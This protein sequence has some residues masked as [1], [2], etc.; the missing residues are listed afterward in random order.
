MYFILLMDDLV[1]LA[2]EY[3]VPERHLGFFRYME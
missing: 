3:S 2:R 1:E